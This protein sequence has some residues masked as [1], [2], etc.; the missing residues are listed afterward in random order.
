MHSTAARPIVLLALLSSACTGALVSGDDASARDGA[1]VDRD[2]GNGADTGATIDVDGGGPAPDAGP[3]TPS[4]LVRIVFP[5][6]STTTAES[7][8]VRV[9]V[10]DVDGVSAVSVDGIDAAMTGADYV[11]EVPLSMGENTLVARVEHAGGA[12][13]TAS[14]VLSRVADDAGLTRGATAWTDQRAFGLVAAPDDTAAYF[15]D[16]IFDGAVRIDVATGDHAWVACTESTDR[17]ATLGGTGVDI[18]QPLDVRFA[19]EGGGFLV[20]DG[21]QL[22]G[23]DATTHGTRTISGRGTGA[24]P[25][26][27]RLSSTLWDAR[28]NVVVGLDWDA[29]TLV[30]IALAS[31]DRALLSGDGAGSGP[32]LRAPETLAYDAARDRAIFFQQYVSPLYAVDLATGDR[33]ILSDGGVGAGPEIGDP[34]S[35][36]TGPDTAYAWDDMGHALFVIDL[37]SGDRRILSASDVGTG[38]LPTSCELALGEEIVFARDETTLYA[39]DRVTG[40]RVVVS[41]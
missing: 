9:R 11:A 17:C 21:D 32:E 16:D 1:R 18:M 35:I 14:V 28:R 39:F 19:P 6:P 23:I 3:S 38:P 25:S 27:G 12:A 2:G 15:G 31:G 7:I 10:T 8:R 30:T 13:L 4:P 40:D 34:A 36:T 41:R 26:L 37:A 20:S 24:G 5:I 33:S 29:S 22:V